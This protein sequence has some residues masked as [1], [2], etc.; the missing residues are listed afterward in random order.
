MPC[1]SQVW[2]GCCFN[3]G[4]LQQCSPKEDTV[5]ASH[6]LKA[7]MVTFV[8]EVA[9]AA[10]V[11]VEYH[12]LLR[13]CVGEENA[14]LI[15]TPPRRKSLKPMCA[16]RSKPHAMQTR[17]DQSLKFRTRSLKQPTHSV[18]ISL[19]RKSRQGGLAECH[20][21]DPDFFDVFGFRPHTT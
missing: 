10:T 13:T 19:C 2:P 1:S 3:F 15:Y 9:V 17:P 16:Y 8:D 18:V 12:S 11:C 5:Q 14:D 21:D 6:A 4:K 7:L 20:E